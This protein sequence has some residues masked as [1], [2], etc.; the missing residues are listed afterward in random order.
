MKLDAALIEPRR[1]AAI[2]L[3]ALFLSLVLPALQGDGARCAYAQVAASSD[4]QQFLVTPETWRVFLATVS[5][6]ATLMPTSSAVT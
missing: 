5:M 2:G 3:G 6:I 4:E 1:R